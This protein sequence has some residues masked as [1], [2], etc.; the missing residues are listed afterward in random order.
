MLENLQGEQV[1]YYKNIASIFVPVLVVFLASTDNTVIIFIEVV[2][3]LC[4]TVKSNFYMTERYSCG[5]ILGTRRVQWN[6]S[7]FR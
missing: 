6:D 5:Y 7:M 3:L 4:F 1:A 2:L